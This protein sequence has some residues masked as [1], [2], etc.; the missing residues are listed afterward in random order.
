MRYTYNGVIAESELPLDSAIFTP[1]KDEG[2]PT[3]AT[4]KQPEKKTIKKTAKE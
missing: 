3:K 1:V 2:K 4:V